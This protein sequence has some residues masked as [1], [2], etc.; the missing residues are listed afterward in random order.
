MTQ[1]ELFSMYAN[2]NYAGS[3]Q[4]WSKRTGL[5]ISSYASE[6]HDGPYSVDLPAH[7]DG[8][9]IVY[10]T[11]KVTE[12]SDLKP[13]YKLVLRHVNSGWRGHYIFDVWK[14]K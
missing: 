12:W 13:K 5:H 11:R 14:D 8:S 2:Q 10:V 3:I 1:D 7:K 4:A 9:A 6:A